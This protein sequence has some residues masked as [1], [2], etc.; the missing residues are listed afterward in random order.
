MF[1]IVSSALFAALAVAAVS[2]AAAAPLDASHQLEVATRDLDL[3][4][5]R[6]VARLNRRVAIA[7]RQICGTYEARTLPSA[8]IAKACVTEAVA[9]A[10]PKVD[11]AVAQARSGNALASASPSKTT[12]VP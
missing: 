12:L 10:S 3:T 8:A 5:T 11:L 7:A 6:D 1:R 4:D 2:P 9:D